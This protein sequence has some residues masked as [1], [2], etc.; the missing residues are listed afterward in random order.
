MPTVASIL[1]GFLDLLAPPTCLACSEPASKLD[2]FCTTCLEQLER[3]DRRG[4]AF[5]HIGPMARAIQRFKYE[6][7]P[8]FAVGLGRYAAEACVDVVGEV[9]R[10]IPVPLH[11]ARRLERGYDQAALLAREIARSLALPLDLTS[12]ERVRTTGRQVGRFR[13]ERLSALRAAFCA[14]SLEGARVLLVD[15]VLTTGATF[16]AAE[17]ACRDAGAREVRI[18]ALASAPS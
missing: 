3:S 11:R 17:S 15:D 7:H 4:T 16:E 8:E 13:D 6:G 10:V 12:V 5:I 9:D 2:D 18:L 1:T 14:R